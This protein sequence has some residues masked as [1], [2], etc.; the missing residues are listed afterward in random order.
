MPMNSRD[1]I[2]KHIDISNAKYPNTVFSSLFF[3]GG[4]SGMELMEQFSKSSKQMGTQIIIYT[5]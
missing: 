5:A 2:L 4:G 3:W 1:V